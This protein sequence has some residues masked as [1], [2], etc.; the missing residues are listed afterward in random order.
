MFS[1]LDLGKLVEVYVVPWSIN[2]ALGPLRVTEILGPVNVLLARSN[3]RHDVV[4]VDRL[5][6][7][8]E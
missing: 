3:R 5:K 1:G 7:F 6:L 8:M 2:I 4:H